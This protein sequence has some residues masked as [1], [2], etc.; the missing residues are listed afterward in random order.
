MGEMPVGRDGEC[1]NKFIY[2]AI[3]KLMIR[4]F[5]NKDKFVF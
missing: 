2:I 3:F 4:H 5:V 1:Y